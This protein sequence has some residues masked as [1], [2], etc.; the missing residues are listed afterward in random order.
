MCQECH[1]GDISVW[2]HCTG[3]YLCMP[4]YLQ[5]PY[6]C[7]F[8]MSV[9]VFLCVLHSLHLC[10][11][12]FI[13]TESGSASLF[14]FYFFPFVCLPPVSDSFISLFWFF[15][16][17]LISCFSSSHSSYGPYSLPFVTSSLLFFLLY[18]FPVDTSLFLSFCLFFLIFL[19]SHVFSFPYNYFFFPSFPHL[20]ISLPIFLPTSPCLFLLS[21]CLYLLPCMFLFLYIASFFLPTQCHFFPSL[22]FIYVPIVSTP[23]GVLAR[24]CHCRKWRYC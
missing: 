22:S 2:W 6:C 19:S 7:V 12:F 3:L 4:M 21:L 15:F 23:V 13:L 9:F 18:S 17:C 8:L 11:F 24:V 16:L 20:Y 10:L 14:S 1:S 5:L